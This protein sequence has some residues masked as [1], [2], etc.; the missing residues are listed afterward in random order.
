[1]SDFNYPNTSI[2]PPPI[3]VMSFDR[4]HYLEGVLKS[5]KTQTVPPSPDQVI[6][7]QDGYSFNG[8]DVTDPKL[9][10]RCIELFVKIFP[11]GEVRLAR[12]N[13]GVALNF[14]R[15]EKYAFETLNA[16]VALFFEDDLLLSP[17]YLE[18]LMVLSKLALREPLI[19]YVAAYGDH[20]ASLESQKASPHMLIPMQHKWGFALTRRQWEAQLQLLAPYLDIVSRAN[21]RD[22][23]HQAIQHYFQK[24]G[25]GSGGTSQ[26]G[27]KDVASCVLGTT[28]VMTLACF[29]KYIGEVGI[30]FRKENYDSELFGNTELYPDQVS[31]F[32]APSQEQLLKWIAAD[33]VHGERSLDRVR[34][35]TP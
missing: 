26:D 9:I 23:D 31:F 15:A 19:A 32:N 14:D 21:Y 11:K 25:F 29:G 1:M 16:D 18:T 4:P 30:H 3:A 20:K 5:L 10:E 8:R 28:K 24:L 34:G 13:L 6:L 33:R 27:M 2:K 17:H 7:F 35:P 12:E 22:R